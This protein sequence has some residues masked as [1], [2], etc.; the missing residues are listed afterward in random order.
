MTPSD[1][2][3]LLPLLAWLVVAALGCYG[4]YDCVSTLKPPP[5]H[6]GQPDI[7]LI[8]PVRG[9]GPNFSA[10]WQAIC[11]QTWLPRRVIFAL[12]DTRDPA[13]AAI[14]GFASGPA[15]DCVIAGPASVCGQKVQNLLAALA[16]LTPDDAVI[17]FADADIVPDKDWL[18]RLAAPLSEPEIKVVSGYRWMTPVDAHWSSAFIC[19]VNA[20]IATVPRTPAWNIPW[21]GSIA[22]RRETFD[23]LNLPVVWDRALSDDLSLARAAH[24]LGY[25]ITSPQSLLVPTPIAMSWREAIA[26]GRRQYL[27]ARFYLPKLWLLA[28]AATTLPLIGWAV[29]LPLAL[30]GHAAA[31][32]TIVLANALDLLRATLRRRVPG[33]L[34]GTDMPHRMAV[35]DRFATPAVLAF[36]AALI[37]S[38]LF[39]RTI[40]WAGRRYHFDAA[41][42]VAR[43]DLISR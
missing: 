41:R 37:W 20:S 21:G 1:I 35:L 8:I 39:G 26:F 36:H 13:Y 29:A 23:A 15:R 43:I 17:V 22:L 33:E 3:L 18:L 19:A 9:A 34:W 7:A 24:A 30:T 40:T 12:E 10:L 32:A 31:I 16:T 38:T 14:A 25:P 42:N 2:L 6:G 5:D 28:A 4:V 27:L 11:A